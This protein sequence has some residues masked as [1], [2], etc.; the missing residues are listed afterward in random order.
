MT[1]DDGEFRIWD[2]PPRSAASSRSTSWFPSDPAD[3]AEPL[4]GLPPPP[5]PP[6]PSSPG[7]PGTRRALGRS[8]ASRG[9]SVGPSGARQIKA[10]QVQRVVTRIDPWAMLRVSLSFSLCLWL[11][12]VVAG[13][14]MWQAAVVTGSIGKVENFLAQLLAEN[15]FTIDGLRVFEGAAVAGFVLFVCGALFAVVTSVLFNLI[16]SVFGG[17]QVTVVELESAHP[18]AER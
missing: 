17:L 11:I 1:F 8:S 14:V 10:R 9:S 5:L 15:S 18:V 2:D 12:V 6:P 4:S 7:R 13:V 3:P 16:A